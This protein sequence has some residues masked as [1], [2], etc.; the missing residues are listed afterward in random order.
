MISMSQKT[1]FSFLTLLLVKL[2]AYLLTKTCYLTLS[3]SQKQSLGLMQ[4]KVGM[5]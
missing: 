4:Q 3:V 1:D 2:L 5:F